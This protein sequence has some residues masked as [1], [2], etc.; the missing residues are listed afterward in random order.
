[1]KT[2]TESKV[3][4]PLLPERIDYLWSIYALVYDILLLFKP[5]DTLLKKLFEKINPQSDDVIVDAGC[6]TGNLTRL[7]ARAKK[8][9]GIDNNNYMLARANKKCR[10]FKSILI[11][12]CDLDETL[13]LSTGSVD[14]IVCSNVLYATKDPEH[15]VAE[16]ARILKPGGKLVLTNPFRTGIWPM[17]REHLR[18]AELW[19]LIVSV[20]ALP[21][22]VIVVI[23]NLLIEKMVSDN[24]YNF[25][26]NKETLEILRQA[27]FEILSYELSYGDAN[28]IVIAKKLRKGKGDYYEHKN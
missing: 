22:F 25:F 24:Q 7:L 15:V 17:V 27:G 23:I 4:T 21:I 8:V 3:K 9:I 11:W 20:L 19:R 26:S 16:F 5:Y 12:K 28:L 14:K 2:I 6:G 1:V 10:K 13:P 18:T